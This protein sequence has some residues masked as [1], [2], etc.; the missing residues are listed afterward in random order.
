MIKKDTPIFSKLLRQNW[1]YT[2]TPVPS[3]LLGHAITESLL[4]SRMKFLMCGF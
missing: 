4:A 3:L 1:K 2:Y